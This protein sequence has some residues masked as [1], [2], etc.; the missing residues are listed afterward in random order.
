[1]A[2]GKNSIKVRFPP[3]PTGFLHVGSL[4]TALYNFLFARQNNGQFLLRIEDT[5]RAR[6]VAGAEENIIE[7]LQTFG[8]NYDNVPYRQSEHLEKY[9]KYAQELLGK[10]LAYKDEGAIR[11]RMPKEGTTQITDI[12][13]GEVEFENKDQED[14]VLLKSDGYPTYNFA[15]VIDDHDMEI[16]HVIR[17]E[18]F[19]PSTPKYVALHNALGFDIPKY[20]H[21]PLLL[22]KARAKLSKREGDVA[23]SDFSQKGYLKEALLNF[24][25]LLGWH[26][27]YAKA[28]EGEPEK[29]IFSLKELIQ[30]FDLSRVQK[31]GAIFDLDKLNWFQH[32]WAVRLY[33]ENNS[34]PDAHPLFARISTHFKAKFPTYEVGIFGLLWPYIIE[35]ASTPEEYAK[36]PDEFDFLFSD[37]KYEPSILVWK[38]ADAGSTKNALLK[39]KEFLQTL[40]DE[41]WGRGQL[42][43]QVKK[44]IAENN[45][46][47]GTALW[48]LRVSLTGKEKSMG[49]FEILDIL[50]RSGNREVMFQRLDKAIHSML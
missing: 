40:S 15:H 6:L 7:T 42:E 32:I 48:P 5:D 35:R 46:D 3:S 22:N 16:T 4:R 45:L 31:G 50:N 41:Q 30:E 29:E 39:L 25:A 9:Q 12:I 47:T 18:E 17:G 44:F 49:P 24:V 20:A 34:Q 27:S 33:Y 21:L 26:P 13:R 28:S 36:L 37:P 19:I 10:D 11:F 2:K 8:L 23:V 43:E 1:M 14:F 38:K